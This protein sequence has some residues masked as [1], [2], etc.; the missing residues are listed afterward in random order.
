MKASISL[1]IWATSLFT[2]T[3]SACGSF[4][5][6]APW[7]SKRKTYTPSLQDSQKWSSWNAEWPKDMTVIGDSISTGLLGGTRIGG[8]LPTEYMSYLWNGS[9]TMQLG[10]RNLGEV[11]KLRYSPF[12]GKYVTGNIEANLRQMNPILRVINPSFPGASSWD[13]AGLVQQARLNGST[14]DFVVIEFGHND[15]CSQNGNIPLLRTNYRNIM[16]TILTQNPMARVLVL[17]LLNIPN[18]Y[19][20]APNNSTA[21]E[22]PN[23]LGVVSFSCKKIRDEIE[24]PCPTALARASEF[25]AWAAI[26]AQVSQEMKSK[27]P[28]A[29]IAV[30][31]SLSRDSLITSEKIAFDCF[32]PNRLGYEI[33]AS[34]SWRTISDSQLFQKR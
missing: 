10:L 34:E 27:F 8:D 23:T 26:P 14:M 20:V 19:K 31:E 30:V 28:R 6:E 5:W 32:H 3:L 4:N 12:T 1:A 25:P 29:K 11:E 22:L 24:A 33:I 18:L 7:A 21:T 13:M 15:Y 17:S 9:W 2:L 16:S